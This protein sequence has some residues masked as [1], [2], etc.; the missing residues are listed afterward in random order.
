MLH[1]HLNAVEQHLL[2]ISKIPANTGHTLHRGT[3]REAFIRE[4]LSSHVSEKVAIGTGELIDATSQPRAH[5]NQFDIVVYR[6]DYPRL[7]FGGGVHGFLA[8][9]VVATI[10]VKS[11]LDKAAIEQAVGAALAAKKLERHLIQCFSA[12]YQ[13]RSVL[14]YVIAYDGPARMETV[15]RWLQ[16]AQLARSVGGPVLPVTNVERIAAAAPS[17]DGVFVLGKGFWYFD[18]V[19][20]GLLT[21]EARAANPEA[22]AVYCDGAENN[23]LLFFLFLTVAVSGVSG[24]WVDP[25]PYVKAAHFGPIHLAP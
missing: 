5:R 10:E 3:P 21:D 23:L 20:V 11:V 12:G 16:E 14:S 19:P 9:S 17:L 24:S 22:R 15:Q 8:E 25:L 2:A 4:F 1:H 7:D 13:P 18:N 6:R